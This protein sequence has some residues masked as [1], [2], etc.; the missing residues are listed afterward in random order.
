VRLVWIATKSPWPPVDGGRLLLAETLAALAAAGAKITLVAPVRG[1]DRAEAAAA[2]SAWCRPELVETAPRS[3]AAAAA[4]SLA[5]GEAW[6]V[7]RH[8]SR[9]LR[10][11]VEREIAR[12]RPDL[13][14]A[15]QLQ[16]FAQSAPAV[17]AG[18]PRLLRAQNVESSLWSQWGELA[19]GSG[20]FLR[21]REARRL[22]RA[23]RRALGEAAAT[24]ALSSD[25]ALHFAALD[26]AARIE[27]L[28]PPFPA[29]LPAGT[30]RLDGRPALVLFGSSGWEPNRRAERHLLSAVW[31]LVRA[32]L[33][34]ARLH[35]FGGPL[36][37]AS[38]GVVPHRPPAESR[39]AFSPQ[40][41][42]VLPLDLAS[43]VR[44]RIL[45]AWAR[46]TP[47][48]ASRA[49]ASG[50]RFTPGEELLLATSAEECVR[51]IRDYATTDGLA[52]RLAD[53][54]RARLRLDHDPVRFAARFLE[55]ARELAGR[56]RRE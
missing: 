46:G 48:L 19:G 47:V 32:E 9:A 3:R 17:R 39:D 1:R 27:V 34:E 40:A 31:P 30:A 35:R 7:A 15:E 43:G 53:A 22:A 49:A 2:L 26:P 54:G 5:T 6:S 50:L 8:D 18:I 41:L 25:D 20:R 10:A 28:A 11:A 21:T 24:V 14:V 45:E 23:E 42:L 38:P 51:E 55:L 12:R 44:M 16:A 37:G 29:E 56:A 13:V 4:R 33:P 52:A 36:T